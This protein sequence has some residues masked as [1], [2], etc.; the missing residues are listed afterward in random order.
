MI[1]S[2]KVTRLNQVRLK[3]FFLYPYM[4]PKILLFELAAATSAMNLCR[5]SKRH[6]CS[7]PLSR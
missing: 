5:G 7:A 6:D 1:T 3:H 2:A 4:Q